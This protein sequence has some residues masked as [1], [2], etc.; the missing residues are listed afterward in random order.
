MLG[1]VYLSMIEYQKH[2]WHSAF[3]YKKLRY[4]RATAGNFILNLLYFA[5]LTF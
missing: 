5:K 4:S 1:K 2:D 3:G